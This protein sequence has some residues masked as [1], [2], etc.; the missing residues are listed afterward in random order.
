MQIIKANI[1]ESVLGT[2]MV[3]RGWFSLVFKR[4]EI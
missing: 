3:E 1:V 2:V 4:P